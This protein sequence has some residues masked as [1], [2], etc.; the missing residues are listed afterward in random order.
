MLKFH[1]FYSAPE[2]RH[3]NISA[4]NYHIC[5]KWYWNCFS[6]SWNCV[7]SLSC[8]NLLHSNQV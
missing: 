1:N 5:I 3:L 8:L 4:Q 6:W 7:S 2:L